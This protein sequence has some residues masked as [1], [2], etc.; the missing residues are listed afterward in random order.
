MQIDPSQ[1]PVNQSPDTK[2]CEQCTCFKPITEFR[3]RS[4]DGFVRLNQCRTCHNA[5]ERQR[6][7]GRRKQLNHRRMAKV[8]TQLKNE[9]RHDRLELLCSVMFRQFG[10]L[11]GLVRAWQAYFQRASRKGGFAAFRSL[12][13]VVRLTQDCEATVPQPSELSDDE[14]QSGLDASV[15]QL[16]QQQP[17]VA[18]AAAKRLGWT[19]VPTPGTA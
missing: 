5:T 11:Q 15:A 13:A 17:E 9:D 6:R 10:G 3:R 1:S 14:L 16:I 18:I 8:L 7:N 4:R 12:Q 2:F 19:V